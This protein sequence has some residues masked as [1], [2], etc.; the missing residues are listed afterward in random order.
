MMMSEITVLNILIYKKA[1]LSITFFYY[2][3]L[4]TVIILVYFK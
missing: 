2:S 1:I 4:S 3:F